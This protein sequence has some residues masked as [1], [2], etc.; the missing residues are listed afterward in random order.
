[1]LP[2]VDKPYDE[3]RILLPILNHSVIIFIKGIIC[4]HQNV[5]I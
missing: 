3:S 2:R 4:Q 1:M 5:I